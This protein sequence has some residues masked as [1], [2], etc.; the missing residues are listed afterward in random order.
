MEQKVLFVILSVG[1]LCFQVIAAPSPLE[2]KQA[3]ALYLEGMSLLA[4]NHFE[5]AESLFQRVIAID[6]KHT[7]SY[8]MLGHLHLK[9]DSLRLAEEA[10]KKARS[11]DQN[12]AP[13]H[14]GLGLVAL[15]RPKGLLWA[16]KY[17]RT[18]TKKDPTYTEAYYN[19][20]QVYHDIGDTKE[21]DTYEKL[22]KVTPDHP[23]AW[24]QMGRIYRDGKA[25]Q[26][27]DLEKA[28][29]AYRQQLEVN[30]EHWGA[31]VHLGGVLKSQN[32]TDEAISFLL[33]AA[34]K[35]H[36]YQQQAVLELAQVFQKRREYDRAEH[37]FD[38][39][40]AGR[41]TAEQLVYYDL[42]L[43]A[44]DDELA[45]FE[46][47]PKDEWKN[48][49]GTFWASR[50]PAPV[51][52]ANERRI[53]HYRRVAYSREHFGAFKF[54]W[55]TRGDVYVRYG[56]PAHISK[57]G[58]IMFETDPQVLRVKERII[59]QAGE[60]LI[61]LLL[62]NRGIY[63]VIDAKTGDDKKNNFD[64]GEMQ[65]PGTGGSILGWPVFMVRG[66]WEYWIYTNVGQG[67]EVIFNQKAPKYPYTF[68]DMPLQDDIEYRDITGMKNPFV[69]MNK[70]SQETRNLQGDPQLRSLKMLNR[71]H[72][73][74]VIGQLATQTPE[75]YAPDFASGPLD[76]YFDTASFKGPSDSTA[77]EVYFG[78]PVKD[79]SAELGARGIPMI[80]LKRGVALFDSTNTPVYREDQEMFYTAKGGIDTTSLAFIPELNR[81]EIS[82][83]TYRMSIQILDTVSQKSQVYN[84]TVTL[85]DYHA[86]MLKLSDI[87]LASSI[88]EGA[89]GKFTKGDLKVVPNPT[90]SYMRG[91]PVYLYYEIYNLKRD[92][93]GRTKYR[94]IYEVHS[95]DKKP[96]VVQALQGLGKL[97]GR[98]QEESAITIAYEHTGDQVD[99]H[100]YVSLDLTQAEVGNQVVTVTVVDENANVTAIS[101]TTVLIQ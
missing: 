36:A 90:R 49:A 1:M 99:D 61:K 66:V 86:D 67:I 26:F 95:A 9:R 38:T 62:T 98:S 63:N 97:L 24:F 79:L 68:V 91:Q 74:F 85:T 78:I 35:Q 7:P 76:F 44:K 54:P 46:A 93:F 96:V 83:G 50:D 17:F 89:T 33:R 64:E 52:E 82:P 59:T 8:V 43:V 53:E 58:D 34:E 31:M 100:G 71:M 14:N 92:A 47:T 25:S 80:T 6:E 101:T 39:Y 48:L 19:L 2:T 16:I 77:L 81:S 20:A 42:S 88:T 60:D 41:D 45:E 15:Q 4:Q 70:R 28:E 10:F 18:A 37:V 5:D 84:Q 72:P 69:S 23:D 40:I 27:V 3:K 11:I 94:V 32:K 75:V 13:A 30:P 22:V 56:E 29:S 73:E 21:L 65:D 55:D 51:T 57:S 87:Q 12:Y